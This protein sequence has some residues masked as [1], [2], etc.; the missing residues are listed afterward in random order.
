MFFEATCYWVYAAGRFFDF[1]FMWLQASD[2]SSMGS[3]VGMSQ[4]LKSSFY[5]LVVITSRLFFNWVHPHKTIIRHLVTKKRR[6][7]KTHML[8]LIKKIRTMEATY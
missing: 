8:R 5:D 3:L 7:K 2:Y 1:V 4:W 6:H